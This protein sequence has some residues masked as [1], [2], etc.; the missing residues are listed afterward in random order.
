[1]PGL[2]SSITSDRQ[3]GCDRDTSDQDWPDSPLDA[4][5]ATFPALTTGP[6]PMALDLDTLG[7]DTGLPTGVMTL[8][9]L[10]D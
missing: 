1:V 5:D 10:R 2:S 8:P 4:D 9:A 7:P 6:D 3:E